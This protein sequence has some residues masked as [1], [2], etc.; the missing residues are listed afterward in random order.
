MKLFCMFKNGNSTEVSLVD[1]SSK[2]KRALF[3]AYSD[4]RI[5]PIEMPNNGLVAIN[6]SDVVML[7][8][9]Q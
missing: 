1:Y 8:I 2:V 7:E 9:K 6:F 4:G 3:D 5:F